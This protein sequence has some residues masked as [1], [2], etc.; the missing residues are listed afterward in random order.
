[1]TVSVVDLFCGV[2][3][4][5][6]GF[7]KQ[8]FHVVAGIDADPKCRYAYEANN[9]GA[10][11]IEQDLE[12]MSAT[13][14]LALYP[15]DDVKVLI[16]CAPCQPFSKYTQRYA[17][18]EN[19]DEKWRL[20]GAFARLIEEVQPAIVSME[21]VPELERHA[22]FKEFVETLQREG[23][24]TWYRVV[25]CSDYGVPQTRKR[26]VLLASK[27]GTIELVSKS[28]KPL[29]TVRQAIGRLPP[30]RAGEISPKDR[31]HRACNLSELNLRRIQCTPEGGTWKDWPQELILACHK[32]ETGRSYGSIYGRMNWDGLAPT[33]TTEF[34]GIGSGRFGHPEQNR[35]ISLREGALLQTFPR[36]YQ[37]VQRGEIL[38]IDAVAR[39]IGN[40][41]PVNL[42]KAIARSIRKHLEQYGIS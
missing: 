15:H 23:Y 21:N 6:H 25:A 4:M 33:I 26:L 24:H 32:K 3:G 22:I 14:L 40:A 12:T 35:A 5:T 18:R 30:L 39:H 27:F 36:S 38:S 16:G 29:R 37:F 13:D 8:G 42:G 20:V 31:V 2:G 17:K 11:F 28:R 7:V 1:M 10:R 9:G 34:H 19:K 41:V